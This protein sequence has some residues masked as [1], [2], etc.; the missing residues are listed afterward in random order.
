MKDKQMKKSG[1]LLISALLAGCHGVTFNSNLGSY[2]LAKTKTLIVEEYS[3]CRDSR[4]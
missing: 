4:F 3:C 2:T 1:L